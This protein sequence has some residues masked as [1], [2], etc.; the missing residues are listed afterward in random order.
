M[1][2]K[3]LFTLALILNVTAAQAMTCEASQF[4]PDSG[5]WNE[6][7]TAETKANFILL[8]SSNNGFLYRAEYYEKKNIVKLQIIEEDTGEYISQSTYK[9]LISGQSYLMEVSSERVTHQVVCTK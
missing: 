5:Y 6:S 4:F 3:I 2:P 9:N 7:M 8:S 1:I